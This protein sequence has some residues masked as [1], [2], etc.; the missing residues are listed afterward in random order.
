M[1]EK[2]FQLECTKKTYEKV[3]CATVLNKV[4]WV[5]TLPKNGILFTNKKILFKNCKMIDSIVTM[6]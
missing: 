2:T 4:K 5:L 6:Q 1:L 3:F